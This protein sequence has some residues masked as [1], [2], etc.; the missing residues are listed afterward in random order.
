MR[1]L[2]ALLLILLVSVATALWLHRLG[3]IVLISFGDWTVQTSILIFAVVVV[4]ALAVF[5]AF[6]AIV[7]G[8]LGM[9]GRFGDWQRQ[10]RE[11]RARAH[12]TKGLLRLAEGRSSEAEKL[13]LKDVGR[14]E[15]PLLHYLAAAIAA[16]RLNSYEQRDK[17]LALADK[18]S[19][20]AGLAVG[21]IQAQLQI[22]SRQWEQALA[23]LN[24]LNES[25]PNHPRVQEMLL[26]T[27]EALEEWDRLE[28]LLPAARR[29]QAVSDSE[30]LRLE[31]ALAL[32]RLNQ[33][34]ASGDG[35]ILEKTWNGLGKALRQDPTLLHVYIDGLAASGQ[36]EQAER[37]LRTHLAKEYNRDLVRRYGML[38]VSAPYKALAQVEKW[39]LDR[40]DDAVLLQAAGRFALQANL[41]GRARSYLEAAVACQPDPDTCHLLGALL[42][43]SGETDAARD[44]YRQALEHGANGA[45]VQLSQT[46]EQAL[47]QMRVK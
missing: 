45:H 32:H 7:R 23:T 24:Y 6:I 31:R 13:L 2:I 30:L 17:Y 44:Y 4:A 10:R 5:Y 19:A 42:E 46:E 29:Q 14:S 16:Q 25:S 43:K 36:N 26:R 39:L 11:H 40:P 20:K 41:W 47:A 33:A 28:I 21:L 35:G 12:L 34:L 3:G 18:T 22:E 1:K 37:L 8:L 27:C 9:P 38:P 15:T